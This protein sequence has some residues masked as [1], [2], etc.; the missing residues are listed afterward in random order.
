[1][2]RVS[3]LAR[4]D[5]CT[6]PERVAPPPEAAES[7]LRIRAL[8]RALL[9]AQ[10][11]REMYSVEVLAEL[12]LEHGPDRRLLQRVKAALVALEASGKLT[13]RYEPAAGRGAK[14]G[15]GRRYFRARGQA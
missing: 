11:D 13:S 10:P 1:M 8:V 12:G 15:L 4:R 9:E 14:S 2:R 7:P 3:V 5:G 6:A